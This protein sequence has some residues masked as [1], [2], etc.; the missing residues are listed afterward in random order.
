MA[1]N[2]PDDMTE[3]Q[4]WDAFPASD[5][6]RR[7]DILGN[8]GRHRMNDH[9]YD[10]AITLFEEA[11]VEFAQ[12]DAAREIAY[13]T[14][15]LA[16]CLG[17]EGNHVQALELF[18]S[19]MEMPGMQGREEDLAHAMSGVADEM[20]QL[21][22]YE[23]AVAAT[24]EA[25]DYFSAA[26]SDQS[27]HLAECFSNLGYSLNFL[28]GR[29]DE[30]VE[31]LESAVHFSGMCGST[32]MV[33]SSRH[34][35]SQALMNQ[36][37]YDDALKQCTM[38]L[39]LTRVCTC[40]I[41]TADAMASLVGIHQAMNN[42]DLA[43]QVLAELEV[44]AT[45]HNLAKSHALILIAKAEL[46]SQTDPVE[47]RRLA[48]EALVFFESFND[49]S[50][51]HSYHVL[52]AELAEASQQPDLAIKHLQICVDAIRQ[53]TGIGRSESIKRNLARLQ[54][55]TGK[56]QNALVWLS[57]SPWVTEDSSSMSVDRFEHLV[58]YARA[59]LAD[60][61]RSSAKARA[62][63]VL[64]RIEGTQL[65]ELQAQ[66]FEVIAY[67]DRHCDPLSSDNAAKRSMANYVLGDDS[68]NAKRI[69]T[70]FFT[71]PYATL[72]LIAGDNDRRAIADD[73]RAVL[74]LISTVDPIV[75]QIVRLNESH[76][77]PEEGHG[78]A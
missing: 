34:A 6:F 57:S 36:Y 41:C 56:Y 52:M 43:R 9:D 1:T 20:K 32:D 71:T 29:N 16:R 10:K 39:T 5:G 54:I 3:Q 62:Q 58:L 59:M 78:I 68:S 33:A 37:R 77:S 55:E 25:I 63:Q 12:V 69:A 49:D 45:K 67:A 40:Q 22:D 50:G 28:G 38:A 31:A 26:Q 4:L 21:N 44:L 47:S 35:L 30:V 2:E 23:G 65:Y 8:L 42:F 24:K 15:L 51:I 72:S 17:H 14:Y 19:I 60:G 75:D 53:D 46:V 66:A 76:Q 7:A 18:L 61:Q 70:D 64:S 27:L 11:L 74:E 13:C 48:D 73:S